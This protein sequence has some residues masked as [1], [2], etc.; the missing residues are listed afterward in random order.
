MRMS[1]LLFCSLILLFACENASTDT[2]SEKIAKPDLS[3]DILGTWET[4]EIEVHSPTY[5]GVDT[6]VH[7]TIR[8]GDWGKYFGVRPAQTVFTPDGKLV[9]T[10]RMKNGKV[11]DIVNGLWKIQGTDSLLV[12]EP[13]KTLYYKHELEN[14]LL[15]LTGIVDWD[16]DGEEDDDYRSVMRLVSKT[17]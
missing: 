14:N 15:T 11:A 4:I 8:E 2:D 7:Q 5:Q 16:F 1:T 12:I 10:H 6:T 13:N 17:Q 9:R 3:Q